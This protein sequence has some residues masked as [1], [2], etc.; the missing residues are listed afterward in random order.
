VPSTFLSLL[1]YARSAEVEATENFT[2]EA[3]AACI[4]AEARPFLML[5]ER[6]SVLPDAGEVREVVVLT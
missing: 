2:T 3:L 5:L 6:L 4:R 1:R